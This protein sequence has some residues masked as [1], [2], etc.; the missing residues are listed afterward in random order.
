MAQRTRYILDGKTMTLE[1]IRIEASWRVQE[2]CELQ[3]LIDGEWV[4]IQFTDTEGK[5]M[6]MA[7]DTTGTW[8][9]AEGETDEER[10]KNMVFAITDLFFHA[11]PEHRPLDEECQRLV[12]PDD[13]NL[14]VED[15]L[16]TNERSLEFVESKKHKITV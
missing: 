5:P 7:V 8:D 16:K 4:G 2:E 11:H 12:N 13:L 1:E 3:D 6:F 14:S 9:D 15:N 10:I